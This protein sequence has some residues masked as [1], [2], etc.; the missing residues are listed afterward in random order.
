MKR[1]AL[2]NVET[3]LSIVKFDM[4]M[5]GKHAAAAKAVS[6]GGGVGLAQ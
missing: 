5:A 2:R 4:V 1:R 3:A 6:W